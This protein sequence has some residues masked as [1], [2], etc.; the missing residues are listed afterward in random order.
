MLEMARPLGQME[1]R[2]NRTAVIKK[3]ATA[4]TNRRIN[5]GQA[6]KLGGTRLVREDGQD[7]KYGHEEV[8]VIWEHRGDPRGGR[9]SRGLP[10]PTFSPV[11]TNRYTCIANGEVNSSRQK[12]RKHHLYFRGKRGEKLDEKEIGGYGRTCEK[13]GSSGIWSKKSDRAE[14]FA[15]V[16]RLPRRPVIVV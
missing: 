1:D 8:V 16:E 4:A 7:G 12:K 10:K 6:E 3:A 15:C 11:K 14:K 5:I 9:N 2:K 13:S